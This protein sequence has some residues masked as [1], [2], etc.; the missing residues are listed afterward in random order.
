MRSSLSARAFLLRCRQPSIPWN[1]LVLRLRP[2]HTTSS[3]FAIKTQRL[4]D[5]GEGNKEVQIIQ[6]YVSEGARV[7]EWD[8]LCQVQS[9]K[10]ADD[11]TARFGGVIKKI[12]WE[13][14]DT[15]QTG[16]PLVDIDVVGEDSKEEPPSVP[17]S[18][19]KAEEPEASEQIST[20]GPL[21]TGTIGVPEEQGKGSRG[22]HATL[23]TPA[24]RGL[25]KEHNLD[26]TSIR[27][28][29]RDGRVLKEDVHQYLKT[30]KTSTA[31]PPSQPSPPETFTPPSTPAEET[32]VP[33]TPIQAAMYRSM[34]ASNSIPHFLFTSEVDIT[35][36]TALRRRLN[37]NPNI[38]P[39]STSPSLKLT[40][41]PFILKAL[42]LTLSAYPILNSRLSPPPSPS[43]PPSLLM[44]PVPNIGLAIATPSGLLVPVIPSTNTHSISSLAAQIAHLSSLANAGKLSSTHLTGGTITVSNIGALGGSVVAPRIVE[45]Q[46]VIVGVGRARG[47]P[48][49]REDVA[50]PEEGGSGEHGG[51]G[52]VRREIVTLS[53]AADHRVV[54][55]ATVA[56]AAG[57]VK[58][59]LEDLGRLCVELR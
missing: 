44:R 40:L 57:L 33:M 17:A 5:I 23:A 3:R 55:G 48:M 37:A 45:G 59:Y 47:V 52:L 49:F 9:D 13:P 4:T 1:H 54:D 38:S 19:I 8:N 11:I 16:E 30:R 28:T 15:V 41:L 25:L 36:L 51:T 53:W 6:W 42:T 56:R 22:K 29:G 20:E 50:V 58:G 27:G 14:D 12:H 43:S 35:A 18:E 39:T 10:A 34:T 24:V 21:Y 2:F 46:S 32:T 31:P 7:E 26:I